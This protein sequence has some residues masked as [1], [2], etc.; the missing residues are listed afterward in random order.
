MRYLMFLLTLL[1]T[2]VAHA[3]DCEK[4]PDCEELGYTKAEDP[5]C[6]NDGYMYCPFNQE[7]KLC[8][9]YDC[10][11]L[12]FT[13]S[14]KTSWC[15]KLIKCKGDEKM[16]LCQNL[17]EVGD[18]FYSDGSC[19][20]AKDYDG[21]KIPVGVVYYV[22]DEG[23]HGKVINL[24]NLTRVSKSSAFDPKNPY[25]GNI[26]LYWGYYNYDIPELTNYNSNDNMLTQLQNRAPDLY[27]GKGNTAKILAVAKPKCDKTENTKEYYQYCMPQAAQ[28]AHD[29]YPLEKLK[30]DSKVG[31]GKWYLPAIGEL[32][33]L[34]GYDN[35]R[36]DAITGKSGAND[37]NLNKTLVNNTLSILK[38][39]NLTA[40]L[41]TNHY[42]WSSTAY[43]ST[44]SWKFGMSGGFRY[45][46]NRD[47]S[48]TDTTESTY[49]RVSL[50]F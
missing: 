42:Y 40:E 30:E 13:T 21:T 38:N 12:G 20:Y 39:K 22:T 50:E 8:V 15:N 29:F 45:A 44:M 37:G 3:L 11:K 26:N 9:Q 7:Y 47:Y 10:A 36:I 48:D 43:S 46:G 16:T 28:A 32:M 5:N 23:R 14:D 19:G 18:V 24:Q 35:T 34:Y 1:F 41:L 33:D 17:C 27:D 6:A 49:I 2:N 31:Q 4:V 25:N